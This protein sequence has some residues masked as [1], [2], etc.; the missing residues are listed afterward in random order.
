MEVVK[1]D[2][3]RNPPLFPTPRYTL[4]QLRTILS[5]DPQNPR[6]E[7][8]IRNLMDDLRVPYIRLMGDRWYDLDQVRS[9]IMAQQAITCQP[10]RAARAARRRSAPDQIAS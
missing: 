1:T 2:A 9:A 10:A 3:Q 8:T 4:E 7:R 6:C 5:P